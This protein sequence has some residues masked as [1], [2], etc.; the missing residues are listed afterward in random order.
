MQSIWTATFKKG[1]LIKVPQKTYL[2]N[3]SE[4]MLTSRPLY[5]FILEDNLPDIPQCYEIMIDGITWT[6]AKNEVYPGG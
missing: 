2:A 4:D 6:V 3:D 5:G 1:D